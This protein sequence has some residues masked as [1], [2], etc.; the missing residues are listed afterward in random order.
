MAARRRRA[1][2]G[3]IPSASNPASRVQQL[4]RVRLFLFL[5]NVPFRACQVCDERALLSGA[6]VV[7]GISDAGLRI[8]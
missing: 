7:C 3:E 4:L 1:A 5:Q 2:P 6:S 8:G